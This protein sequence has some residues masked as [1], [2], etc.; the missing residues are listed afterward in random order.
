MKT[1]AEQLVARMANAPGVRGVTYSDNGLFAGTESGEAILVPGFYAPKAKDRVS[2]EDYVGPNYFGIVGIPILE[3]R[4]IE[5][6]DTAA[7]TRVAVVNQAFVKYFF[8]GQDPI[9]RQFRID[10]RDWLDKPFTI[11]GVS[12]NAKDHSYT[13]KEDVGP[14]FYQAYQQA[15]ETSQIVLEVEVSGVP[16]AA[17]VNIKSQIA[18]VDPHL[19]ISFVRT[20]NTLV[21]NSAAEGIALAKLSAFFAAL[22]LLLAC[23]GLYGIMSYSVAAR[24][25]EIGVRMALGARRTDVLRLVLKEGMM[26]VTVGLAAGIPL[27]L[28]SSRL[29]SSM[30]YGLKSTDPVSLLTVMAILVLVALLAGFI[31]SRRATK[32]DPMIALR[33][34]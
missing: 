28:V 5:A 20:L 12:H 2:Y 22:A 11:I 4:G 13:L 32:V 31:P 15:P 34:E 14:R 17:V 10:D 27:A 25:R 26:L 29:L 1:L 30:L 24:T 19:P 23:I 3:G 21:K 9:G 6:R 33:Y 16:T 18:S 8:H 7:S